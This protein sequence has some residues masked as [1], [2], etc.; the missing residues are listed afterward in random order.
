MSFRAILSPPVAKVK[1]TRRKS[2]V[3]G[4]PSVEALPLVSFSF[5]FLSFA[6]L[7][8]RVNG[9][10][11]AADAYASAEEELREAKVQQLTGGKDDFAAERVSQ[12]AK[13][14]DAA[15][16]A[17]EKARTINVGDISLRIRLPQRPG[18]LKSEEE[19]TPSSSFLASAFV[20]NLLLGST[21]F[22]L[23]PL[24]F[25]MA[26]DPM[27]PPSPALDA[28]FRALDADDSTSS[29]IVSNSADDLFSA[30]SSSRSSTSYSE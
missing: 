24:F 29:G 21:L 28:T 7:R 19:S 25:L 11:S 22:L 10:N 8:T 2:S 9:Y 18:A 16:I 15:R 13:R 30:F 5:V 20:R 17:M 1:R 3:L 23:I 27:K 6:W 12:A 14:T 4:V 26:A